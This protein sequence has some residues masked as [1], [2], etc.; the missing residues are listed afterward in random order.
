MD[1]RKEKSLKGHSTSRRNLCKE[2]K[3]GTCRARVPQRNLTS[4]PKLWPRE[5]RCRAIHVTS[6]T[7]R[8]L[9]LYISWC[10]QTDSSV[11]HHCACLR[12]QPLGRL[13]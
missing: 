5:R 3:T 12:C 10:L 7:I 13:L 2:Q 9:S 11:S 4:A 8:M 1:V 6:Q